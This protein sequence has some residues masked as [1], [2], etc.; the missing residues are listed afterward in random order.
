MLTGRGRDQAQHA[1]CGQRDQHDSRQ[2]ARDA[3]RSRRGRQFHRHVRRFE[4]DWRFGLTRDGAQT[5]MMCGTISGRLP[6]AR[7]K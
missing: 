7:L 1:E 2:F 3:V 6:S 5:S 4:F